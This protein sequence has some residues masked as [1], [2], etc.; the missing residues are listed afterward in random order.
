MIG[1]MFFFLFLSLWASLSGAALVYRADSR[2]PST[3]KSAGGFLSKGTSKAGA[4]APDISLWNHVN[5]DPSSGFSRENDG[6]V[7]TTTDLALATS[8]VTRL[9]GGNGYVYQIQVAPNM[10]D[11]QE[12][13]KQYNPFPEEKEYAALGG[14]PYNQIVGWSKVTNRKVGAVEKNKDYNKKLFKRSTHA[15]GQYQ[16]AAFPPGHRAWSQS[17][18]NAYAACT[19]PKIRAARALVGR[20]T[21]RPKKSNA[22]YANEYAKTMYT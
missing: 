3:I 19:N 13:L 18:W 1:K 17:P 14:I 7:S 4:V 22:D 6:Y 11:C 9:L 10:I 21:C 2:A 5:G 16:L 15:T 20:A 8:W 12:I